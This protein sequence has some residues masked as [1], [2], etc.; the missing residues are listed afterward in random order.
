MNQRDQA[1]YEL[2]ESI[3]QPGLERAHSGFLAANYSL[4]GDG[5]DQP[6]E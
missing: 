2:H 5:Q 1:I 3:G 6:M 4:P